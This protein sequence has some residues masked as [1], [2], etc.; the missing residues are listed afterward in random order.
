ME[1]E[2]ELQ[3]ESFEE[4]EESPSTKKPKK[5][6][7]IL[8]LIRTVQRKLPL[9]TGIA[10]VMSV[11]AWLSTASDAPTYGGGFRLL[12]EPIT[13]EG[14]IAEPTAL[15]RTD[16][17][18]PSEQLFKLDYP[19]QLEILRSPRVLNEVYEAVKAKHPE[20][21]YPELVSGLVLQRSGGKSRSTETKILDVMYQ[22]YNP[23]TVQTVLDELSKK[24][25]R[26]SLE[27]RKTR[28][29]EGVK[30]IEDQL[31][32]LQDRVDKLESELQDL[33]QTYD[34][35]DPVSQGQQISAQLLQV[36]DQLK[37]T[38]QD[39]QE[40]RT[41][42]ATLQR[43]LQLNP[44]EAIAVSSLSQDPRYQQLLNSMNE[45]E[46]QI[47]VEAVRF[48]AESPTMQR[49]E[50][51]RANLNDL[52]I[53]RAQQ[54]LGGSATVSSNSQ[55]STVQD[56]VRQGMIQQLV[57]A[58]NKMEV[59]EVRNRILS[60]NRDIVERQ[61]QQYPM[62][63]RRYNELQRQLG[64]A[65]RTLDQLLSQRESLRVAAA[66]NQ[67]PW[68]LVSEPRIPRDPAGNPIPDPVSSRKKL[69]VGVMA[70]VMMGAGAAI[71]LEKLQDIFHEAN[72]VKDLIP[73]PMLGSIPRYLSGDPSVGFLM[74]TQANAKGAELD[75]EAFGFQDAFNSL[76][77][78]LRFLVQSASV[79]SLVICSPLADDGKTTVALNLAETA[80]GT[81]QRVLL[82][83]ANFRTPELH[84]KLGLKNISG[85]ADLL[86]KTAPLSNLVQSV[87][88]AENL[89]IL[90]AGHVKPGTTR[91]L[92][93]PYLRRTMES[94]QEAYDLVIYDSPSLQSAI[95]ANFLAAATDGILMVV[96]LR[97][98]SRA[99]TKQSLKKLEEYNISI[100]GSIANQVKTKAAKV[101]DRWDSSD[102]EEEVD[103]AYEGVLYPQ[104]AM[105]FVEAQPTLAQNAE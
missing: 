24:Y 60:Q 16:G 43:Q 84:T 82:V 81:G 97:Q 64:I 93:S 29:S 78:N 83:D 79:R 75:P 39:L 92:A 45:I 69:M 21:I 105:G 49:L 32:T 38:Q 77:A 58:A 1:Q 37:S 102:G 98:T 99:K 62:I 14:R 80:A 89:H 100:V 22:G 27:D 4:V 31:P 103:L 11:L 18:V 72:D 44:S 3:D 17:G 94:M 10:G 12:V 59:L 70:G 96:A 65:T 76:Y 48:T 56:S 47:A 51:R 67:V 41:L 34:L 25:L 20:F 36:T 91:L 13:S 50:Q 87:A 53:Q 104:P 101:R 42:Y 55:I 52:I 66:Q 7:P 68:E 2:F 74:G 35:L 5:A 23:D 61:I 63:S 8:P 86:Q 88:G 33:Q 40:T 28:I 6:S 30:F 73:A 9:I 15:S 57:D 54:I 26:Y 85:F 46:S 19:T 71:L 95:D 90:T